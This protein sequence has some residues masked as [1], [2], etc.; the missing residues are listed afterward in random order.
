[1]HATSTYRFGRAP[2]AVQTPQA[3][4]PELNFHGNNFGHAV[5]LQPAPK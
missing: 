1:V 5:P 2:P 4:G 3:N